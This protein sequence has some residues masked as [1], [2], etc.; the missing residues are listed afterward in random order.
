MSKC[1]VCKNAILQPAQL[2]NDF[3]VMTCA[4]CGGSWIRANEYAIW[5]RSQT[6]GSFDETKTKE[7]SLRFP[8]TE[9]GSA[10]ICPDC[11]HFLRKYQIG[12]MISF[13]LDRCNHCNGVWLD[14]NE[15]QIL[16]TA[17]LHDEINQMFTNPWQRHI[18]DDLTFSKFD[19]M[20][21]ERFGQSDYQKIKEIRKWLQ[22]NPNRN[23]LLAFLLDKDPYSVS[24]Q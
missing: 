24:S 17:D 6:P 21:L 13:H 9:S 2:D 15:W 22:E 11:G 19:A 12:S 14:R 23:T 3:P 7:A 4:S 5:L 10:A 1:P 20:Y 16:K 8:V 18:Q